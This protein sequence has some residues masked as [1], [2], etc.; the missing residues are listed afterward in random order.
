MQADRSVGI[1]GTSFYPGAWNLL[2]RLRSGNQL[3][4]V[5][6]PTNKYDKNAIGVFWGSKQ[7]GHVPRGLAAELAPVM[8][9]GI[10]IK[11]MKE[12]GPVAVIKLYWDDGQPEKEIPNDPAA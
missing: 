6:Q 3:R 9:A 4:V 11:A 2:K 5:R 7:L 12:N 8:D 10:E 1:V